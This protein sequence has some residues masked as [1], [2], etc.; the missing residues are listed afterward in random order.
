MTHVPA[1]A[2]L[3]VTARSPLAGPLPGQQRHL[4]VSATLPRRWLSRPARGRAFYPEQR[5]PVP[6]GSAD[7]LKGV[8]CRPS[9]RHARAIGARRER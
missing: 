8:G 5:R 7:Y 2:P 3:P 9:R 4:F 1:V 6:G